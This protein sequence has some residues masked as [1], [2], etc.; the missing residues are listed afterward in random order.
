MAPVLH[1]TA[2]PL[3]ETLSS[4]TSVGEHILQDI[5]GTEAFA[6]T[7][8]TTEEAFAKNA[9]ERRPGEDQ[10]TEYIEKVD[11]SRS[12]EDTIIATDG[13]AG[14]ARAYT[15]DESITESSIRRTEVKLS[16][17]SHLMTTADEWRS[18]A[19]SLSS[20]PF[21]LMGAYLA[22]MIISLVAAGPRS[23]FG[24]TLALVGMTAMSV[25]GNPFSVSSYV[26]VQHQDQ[27]LKGLKSNPN[28]FMSA[29]RQVRTNSS[30][31]RLTSRRDLS[32]RQSMLPV[33]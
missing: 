12:G 9:N 30:A 27:A 7:Y 23:C 1:R 18:T 2:L 14:L 21:R 4:E 19:V 24:M 26:D 5:D 6:N 28:G 3:V 32:L 33:F 15:G 22:V 17:Y 31:V 29:M 20:K 16:M 13:R 8:V 25:L 10:F 11:E